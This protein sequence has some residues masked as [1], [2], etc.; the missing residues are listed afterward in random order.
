MLEINSNPDTKAH[1]YDTST[2]YVAVGSGSKS[3][4]YTLSPNCDA[5]VILKGI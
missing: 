5:E 1:E 3:D 4:P 2:T